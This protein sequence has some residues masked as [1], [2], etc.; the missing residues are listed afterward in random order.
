MELADSYQKRALV[1]MDLADRLNQ[2]F[3]LSSIG[4]RIPS[5]IRRLR[6]WLG[7][8]FRFSDG[9]VPLIRTSPTQQP[10]LEMQILGCFNRGHVPI[11]LAQPKEVPELLLESETYFD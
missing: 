7:I 2:E 1:V 6:N 3:S 5:P 10:R 4:Q 9:L 11:D 8:F